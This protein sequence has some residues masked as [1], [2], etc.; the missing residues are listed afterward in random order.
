[1]DLLE[2]GAPLIIYMY[3]YSVVHLKILC[4]A[5]D[6]IGPVQDL[7][8]G[9][10]LIAHFQLLEDLGQ[11]FTSQRANLRGRLQTPGD[12]KCRL[13]VEDVVEETG[14]SRQKNIK[15]RNDLIAQ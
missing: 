15:K 13:V 11:T 6:P 9:A 4:G 3:K 1:G 8:Q 10:A 5:L 12:C 7:L 14:V 2:P